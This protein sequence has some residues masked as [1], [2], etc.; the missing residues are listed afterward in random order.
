MFQV[1]FYDV[2]TKQ[3]LGLLH[4]SG[5]G[6][7]NQFRCMESVDYVNAGLG[8]GPNARYKSCSVNGVLFIKAGDTVRVQSLYADTEIDLTVDATYFGGVLF[9]ST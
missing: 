8:R 5:G 3:A 4:E 7:T 2:K 1:L 6:D 9:S